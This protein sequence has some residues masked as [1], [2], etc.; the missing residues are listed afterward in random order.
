MNI[1]DAPKMLTGPFPLNTNTNLGDIDWYGIDFL[2]MVKNVGTG[3]VHWFVNGAVSKTHP[4]G[5]TLKF[6][7]MDTGD[8]LLY[9]GTP[10]DKTGWAVYVGGRYDFTSTG[11]KI[12]LEYNHGSEDW[13]TFAP[14][15]D[16]MWTSK[17]GVRGDVYEVYLIQELKLKPIS[18]Y[19]SKTFFRI[20]YQ[21]YEF[22]YTGSNNWLGSPIKISEMNNTRSQLTAPLKSA[23]D[24]YGTFEV[25]F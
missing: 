5:N 4:N 1:F 6:N 9:S 20:G 14:A 17:L 24:I 3:N 21:Y 11:T 19:L 2:G 22:A 8:G 16:D 25:H 10:Q 7:G 18:S 15:A 12:G 13:I 23:Q